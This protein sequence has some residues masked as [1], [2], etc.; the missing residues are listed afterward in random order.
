MLMNAGQERNDATIWQNEVEVNY[1]EVCIQHQDDTY[2]EK[3]IGGLSVR[4]RTLLANQFGIDP[5]LS[6]AKLDEAIFSQRDKLLPFLLV[7][8]AGYRKLY[9]AIKEAAVARLSNES[10][11]ACLIKD[12]YDRDTM[13]Y[14]LYLDDRDNLKLVLYFHCLQHKG[15]ARLI[16][17]PLP[18]IE[19]DPC[20]VP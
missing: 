6:K 1:E 10:L 7:D 17:G 9:E 14:Y 13:M 8:K 3:W 18:E 19:S 12:D 20:S 11:R 4:S 2:I 15:M 16:L 5:A